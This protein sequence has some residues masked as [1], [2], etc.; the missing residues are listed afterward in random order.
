M[1]EPTLFNRLSRNFTQIQK[2]DCKQFIVLPKK[3]Q[4]K[5]RLLDIQIIEGVYIERT[6]NLPAEHYEFLQMSKEKQL[7]K[8]KSAINNETNF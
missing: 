2:F 1:L 7:F 8:R 6:K 3:K 4:M 5:L